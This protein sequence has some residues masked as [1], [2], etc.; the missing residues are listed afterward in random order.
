MKT[1]QPLDENEWAH[2][3]RRR[4]AKIENNPKKESEDIAGEEREISVEK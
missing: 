2:S 1:V 3:R 4:K